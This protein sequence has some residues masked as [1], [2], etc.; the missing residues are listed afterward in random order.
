MSNKTGTKTNMQKLR[1]RFNEDN[2]NNSGGGFSWWKPNW[3]DNI[4]RVLPPVE[5]DDLFYVKSARH[6]IDQ[7]WYY[8]LKYKVDENGR[9]CK[10]PACDM[11]RKLFHGDNKSNHKIAKELKAK[12]QYF[13]NIIDRGAEDPTKV[14]LYAPG[15]KL[16]N[17]IVTSMLDDDID[18]TDVENGYDFLVKK[19]EG[20]KTDS[21]TFPSYDNSKARRKASPLSEDPATSKEILKNRYDLKKIATFDEVEKIQEAI[22]AYIT[23]LTGKESESFYENEEEDED[24]PS[25]SSKAPQ[26]S[27]NLSKFK[28]GLKK[29][30]T[31]EDLEDDEDDDSDEE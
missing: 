1:E 29:Q 17:K 15:V 9:P 4:I 24:K 31:T 13:M 21:G 5:D 25:T 12:E 7:E 10:C 23:S 14:F 22:D 11:R 2:S 30:L 18:I 28:E 8:C 3:G 26:K 20:Q 16:W 19:E 27:T 6:K